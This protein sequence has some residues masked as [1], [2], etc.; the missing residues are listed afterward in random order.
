M[1]A[2]ADPAG[3]LRAALHLPARPDTA[4]ALLV[5]RAGAVVRVLPELGAA[6]DYRA[7][8]IRLAG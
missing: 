5:D 1:R 6:A 4:T 8:L 3:E 2:L 7:D